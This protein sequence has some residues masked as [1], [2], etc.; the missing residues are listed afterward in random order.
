MIAAL[1][2]WFDGRS[3]RERRMLLVMTAMIVL[4]LL[5]FAI[6]LPVS[7][8]LSSTAVHAQAGRLL[9]ALLPLLAAAGWR[10]APVVL[11]RQARVALGDEVAALLRARLVAV[12]IGE[13]PGLSSPDSL[14]AYLTWQPRPGRTDAERNCLSNIRD[15]GLVPAEAARKL[16]WLAGEAPSIADVAAFVM[17]APAEDAGLSL[18][19][20]PALRRWCDRVR[21]LQ[22]FVAMSGIFPPMA[23][24]PRIAGAT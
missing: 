11:A 19:D 20:R 13:R 2:S 17:I 3:L 8:G 24:T 10:V 7:D 23:N 6:F 14:G 18:R 12:L 5:W 15:G 9:D 22:G 16:M 1:K 4:T 21:F